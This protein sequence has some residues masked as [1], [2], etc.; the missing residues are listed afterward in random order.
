MYSFSKEWFCWT[1]LTVECLWISADEEARDVDAAVGA[2]D[3]FRVGVVAVDV[4]GEASTGSVEA[5]LDELPRARIVRRLPRR[6]NH[7]RRRQ[8]AEPRLHAP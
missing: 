1:F 8:D 6:Q 4:H 2:G 7:F 3:D 5:D